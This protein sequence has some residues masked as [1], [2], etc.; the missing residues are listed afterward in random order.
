MKKLFGR[1]KPKDQPPAL[2]AAQQQ[3]QAHTP[4]HHQFA[5]RPQSQ[6]D[7]D[8]WEVLDTP[9]LPPG[10]GAPVPS[11]TATGARSPSPYSIA[12]ATTTTA[13][14]SARQPGPP[15]T[16]K[17]KNPPA[18]GI[19]GALDPGH[20]RNRSEERFDTPPPPKEK[21]AKKPGFIWGRGASD[22]DKDKEREREREREQRE[23]IERAELEREAREAH[24]GRERR[25]DDNELTRKIGF[26]TATA[27]EDWTLVLD[28]CDHASAS[29]A[30]AKEAVRALRREFKY[31]E[32]AAQLAA[33][34]VRVF[35][36]LAPGLSLSSRWYAVVLILMYILQLWAIMLR[37]S[38]EVF[39]NQSTSRKFLDTLE[40]LLTSSRT[41]PVV[42]ER[43]M[44][45]L[46]A[47]AYASGSKKDA[48]FRGLWR[49]VKPR[50]KPEEG[51]PFDTEDAMFNPPL[52]SHPAHHAPQT[53]SPSHPQPQVQVQRPP[54]SYD[55]DYFAGDPSYNS[56]PTTTTTT[57]NNGNGNNATNGPAMVYQDPTPT[58]PD[59]PEISGQTPPVARPPVK[60]KKTGDNHEGAKDSSKRDRDRDRDEP[61][62]KRDRDRGRDKDR[63]RDRGDRG[64]RDR[65]REGRGGGRHGPYIIP[66]DEDMRRLFTECK[67][68]V[69]NANLL[70]QALAVAGVEELGE[71]V[72]K[73][74][75]KKC[76]DSQELIF[77]QIPWASAG[78]E[79]SRVAKDAEERARLTSSPNG[80]NGVNGSPGAEG[81]DGGQTR[82]EEL[83]ADLLAANEQ[84]MEAL[85]L[86]DD[87]KR[88]ALEREIEM[89][90]RDEV[91]LDPRLKQFMTDDGTLHP[92][93]MNVGGSKPRQH[94]RSG[95]RSRSPS[96]S[97]VP[98]S[99]QPSYPGHP[100]P[101][102]HSQPQTPVPTPIPTQGLAPPPAAP[103]GPRLPG[104]GAVGSRTPSPAHADAMPPPPPAHSDRELNGMGPR[105]PYAYTAPSTPGSVDGEYAYRD[106]TPTYNWNSED[107]EGERRGNG[108]QY[109]SDGADEDA[110]GEE[111]LYRPSAKALGKRRVDADEY[112][113]GRAGDDLSLLHGKSHEQHHFDDRPGGGAPD[114]DDDSDSTH[115]FHNSSAWYAMHPTTQFVY[116]AAAERTQ[117]RIRQGH[118][119]ALITVNGVH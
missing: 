80:V 13:P 74:F 42:R 22:K 76:L 114:S 10:A 38:N 33:A 8:R 86:Y 26:L 109:G 12:P 60:K 27:S 83:L 47:A 107:D 68:G 84:L 65:D 45:V 91:V 81:E 93:H 104:A 44:D 117:A 106:N 67:I 28:V 30:N 105:A 82:E 113:T 94:S 53:H 52:V 59:T 40:D 46:A 92:D 79:R 19:L 35:F 5:T 70:S 111:G 54:S 34:R 116:D 24:R 75:H 103:H 50:D 37:N 7:D 101:L 99:L 29:E 64:D 98:V 89:K 43:M 56:N 48:G 32:P 71:S 73:E 112:D 63:D 118:V 1:D 41:S 69:G 72:I 100:P 102:A 90:S 9:P 85:A 2:P 66:P 11:P 62:S 31:G 97:P 78:A 21:E 55:Y 15:T 115:Q 108:Y 17:K 23:R 3:I 36:S 58:V 18:I 88:V 6:H 25:D 16:L 110:D 14:I 96:P 95:S 20:V 57:P 4:I 61:S 119:S 51:M 49:R 77:T 87:L 39:I